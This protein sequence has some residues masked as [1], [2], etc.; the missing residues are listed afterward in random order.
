MALRSLSGT[1]ARDQQR[2]AMLAV[3]D[4]L[5]GIAHD[6]EKLGNRHLGGGLAKRAP[7]IAAERFAA[8]KTAIAALPADTPG[9]THIVKLF[10][11][12]EDANRPG[13]SIYAAGWDAIADRLVNLRTAAAAEPAAV[14]SVV[15]DLRKL[16]GDVVSAQKLATDQSLQKRGP[17]ASVRTE[18]LAALR[19]TLIT[20]IG[21][22]R[23][24][25]EH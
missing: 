13:V 4:D 5:I 9:K 22:R 21:A 8:L 7:A 17:A 24:A 16:T 25:T 3:T 10:A 14:K 1:L 2:A 15:E 11:D 20:S 18:R 6:L 23:G 19:N 12:V